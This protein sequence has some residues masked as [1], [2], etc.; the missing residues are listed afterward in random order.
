LAKINHE[1]LDS[2]RQQVENYVSDRRR[3][4]D[5][6][7]FFRCDELDTMKESASFR[8]RVRHRRAWQDFPLILNNRAELMWFC[9]EVGKELDINYIQYI[10]AIKVIKGEP[11]EDDKDSHTAAADNLYDTGDN[12]DFQAPVGPVVTVHDAPAADNVDDAD[13]AYNV[14]LYEAGAAASLSGLLQMPR[15]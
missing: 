12:S 15:S 10:P 11:E 4:Y 5:G 1:K 13:N 7:V 6:F 3:I 9:M 14:N 8:L 2:F